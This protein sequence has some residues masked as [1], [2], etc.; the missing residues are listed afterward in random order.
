[1]KVSSRT[2]LSSCRSNF[3]SA[4]SVCNIQHEIIFLYFY[5]L[6]DHTCHTIFICLLVSVVLFA[7]VQPL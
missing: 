3:I 7:S 6:V 1:M 4:Q 5:V 2:V